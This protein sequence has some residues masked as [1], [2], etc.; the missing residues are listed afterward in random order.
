LL[1]RGGLV[2]HQLP[3][4]EAAQLIVSRGDTLIFA[5]DG[6]RGDFADAAWT[7]GSSQ[8]AANRILAAHATGTDDALVLVARYLGD[9]A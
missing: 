6:V 7:R 1:V 4:I 2:G 5:T 8:A 9:D 3:T